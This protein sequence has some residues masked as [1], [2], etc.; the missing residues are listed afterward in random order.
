MAVRKQLLSGL[1]D[2]VESTKPKGQ[3]LTLDH[4]VVNQNT[5]Y[6]DVPVL[7][8]FSDDFAEKL[9]DSTSLC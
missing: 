5:V 1:L 6:L 2:W 9:I 4:P 3:F 7:K 8:G